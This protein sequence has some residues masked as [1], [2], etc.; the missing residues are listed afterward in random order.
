VPPL[1]IERHFTPNYSS[2]REGRR[3]EGIV[4][5]TTAG[6]WEGTLGWF[7]REESGVSAHYVVGRDGR[8]A[9]VVDEADTAAHAG[10]VLQPTAAFVAERPGN[11][12]LY[13]I[14]I[15]FED[16]G[17]PWG[18]RPDDQYSIGAQLLYE[19]ADRWSISLD[20]EHVFGHRE[21]FAAK[22]CPG[23]LDVDRLIRE[24]AGLKGGSA[25]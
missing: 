24:A 1:R 9:Q 14:G 22:D 12:N 5:H 13:T 17:D 4:L 19:V 8:V 3:P 23:S 11:P 16:G 18:A 21:V 7:A 10:R 2:G 20:R 6:T 15:E 25:A